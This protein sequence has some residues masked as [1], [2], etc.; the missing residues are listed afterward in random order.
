MKFKKIIITI[1]ILI[2][3]IIIARYL[4]TY[5]AKFLDLKH[6]RENGVIIGA[7]PYY[8]E[9]GKEA[10]LVL[11]GFGASPYS[12]REIN[13]FLATKG[14]TVYAPLLPGH[15]T[16]V[17]DLEKV[18]YLDWQNYAEQAY[19]QLKE[20]HTKVYIVGTSL[21]G[22]LALDLGSKYDVDAIVLIN[23]PIESKSG[24]IDILPLIY[25]VERYHIRG[26]IGLEELPIA[27]QLRLYN[28]VPI[29][30]VGQ[31]VSYINIV[32]DDL[33]NINEPILVIQSINDDVV[34]PESAVIILDNVNSEN[35]N[36][37]WLRSSTH[38]NIVREDKELL[39][40]RGYQFIKNV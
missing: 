9:Q 36:I 23:T 35:K 6:E 14:Y 1:L 24:I 39:K 30:T 33:N 7:E 26:F 13:N 38:I 34:E 31:L 19:L 10:V 27:S 8:I 5:V 28:S 18:T 17:F 20:N 4:N 3:L 40:Q 21:G 2:L 16:S 15:G 12:I 29:K 11:H 32:K 37:L 25:L 22:L